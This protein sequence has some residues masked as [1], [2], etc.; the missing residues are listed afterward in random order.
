[1]KVKTLL[2]STFAKKTVLQ[3]LLIGLLFVPT[4]LL[5]QTT[6][7]KVSGTLPV[8]YIN[9]DGAVDVTVK[10][11][12]I[13]A[14]AYIDALGLDGYKNMASALKPDT[15]LVK[16]HGNY[17]FRAF[18]KKPFRLKFSKKVQPLGMKKSKQFLL[19]AAADDAH[20]ALTNLTGY[21]LSRRLGLAWT[22]GAVPVELVF[23]GDYR[24]LYFLTE[25]IKVEKNRV[26][27][28]EQNDKETDPEKVKGGWLVE[29]D[30]YNTDPHI[31]V[32]MGSKTMWVTYHTPEE[33]STVQKEYLQSQWDSIA[34][35]L[36][37]DDPKD[38]EWEKHIDMESLAKVYL[39]RELLQDEEGFHGSCYLYK[40]L[41]DTKWYFGPVWDFGNGFSGN[42]HKY[43]FKDPEF[44]NWIID[45]AWTFDAFRLKV[46]ELWHSFYYGGFATMDEWFDTTAATLSQAVVSDYNRWKGD[47]PA[48]G[49]SKVQVTN[50]EQ[51]KANE[52][53]AF[54]HDKA[55]WLEDQWF[56]QTGDSV[57]IYVYTDKSSDVPYLYWWGGKST[58]PSWPGV[59]MTET[60]IVGD[61][62][63]Y[64]K[65]LPKGVSIIFSL[66]ADGET[67]AASAAQKTQTEDIKNV[68]R[69][70]WYYFYQ[71]PGSLSGYK[72]GR[73]EDITYSMNR[74]LATSVIMPVRT[75]HRRTDA[76]YNLS[77]QRVTGPYKG[78]V[79]VKGQ[80]KIVTR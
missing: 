12:D 7:G 32:N 5:A 22:P 16:G 30:N 29:I 13:S 41:T 25:K 11:K 46:K 79:I 75:M 42:T 8:V 31:D 24:G 48:S 58:A 61:S 15:L 68:E 47:Q 3:T 74:R 52:C 44:S 55:S 14:T 4:I 37:V 76:M 1:M 19:L 20:G 21:E 62:L 53:K 69:D 71:N 72:D 27:I 78:I 60:C 33:L 34:S 56:P 66:V 49:G 43:I 59:K 9:T 64:T 77:G 50:D 18:N 40:D 80:K 10:D 38:Q 2:R 51:A 28:V 26:N 45:R 73:Y 23:N 67:N 70:S 35:S 57:N 63:F 65:R 39:C 6:G 54:I 36:Y 17:T